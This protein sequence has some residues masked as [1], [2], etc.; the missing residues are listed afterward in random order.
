MRTSL[1]MTLVLVGS[2]GFGCGGDDTSTGTGSA[3]TTTVT[4]TATGS[5]STADSSGSG[6]AS[7][8]AE[9]SSGSTGVTA[10]DGSSSTTDA[11]GSSEGTADSSSSSSAG[12]SSSDTGA[13]CVQAQG[14]CLDAPCCD[15]L[16]CCEGVPIP[17]GQA[18]CFEGICPVSD[19]NLKREFAPVDTDDVLERLAT[20]PVTTW[21]YRAEDPSIRHLGP[22]AQD[23]KDTFGVGASEEFIFQVDADG[24]ALASIQALH[25]RVGALQEENTALRETIAGLQSRM[26]ALEGRAGGR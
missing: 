10:T 5:T 18:I 20:V 22:M 6:T 26:D 23:F 14:S 8:T 17:Q 19:R 25:R 13:V 15:G 21:S 2:A 16:M 7:T 24:V 3:T 4:D 9:S 12:S 11:T 1:I